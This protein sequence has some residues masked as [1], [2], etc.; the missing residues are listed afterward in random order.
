MKVT[1]EIKFHVGKRQIV[2]MKKFGNWLQNI[3]K[4]SVIELHKSLHLQTRTIEIVSEST[5][6]KWGTFVLNF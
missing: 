2:S 1:A 3:L 5:A 4:S 6:Q